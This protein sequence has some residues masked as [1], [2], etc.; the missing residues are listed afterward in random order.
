MN[1]FS[2][3]S[4]RRLPALGVK[5]FLAIAGANIVLVLAAYQ[6]YG[7][8]FDQG[9]VEY[10]NTSDEARLTPLIQRLGDGYRAQGNWA[11]ITEDRQRW[12]AMLREVL[13][14]NRFARSPGAERDRPEPPPALTIDPRMLLLDPGGAVLIGPAERAGHAR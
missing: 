9:L 4:A 1:P 11:W 5:L 14:S 13:G 7:Y 3:A 12:Q 8:S 10:L 2:R 6:I